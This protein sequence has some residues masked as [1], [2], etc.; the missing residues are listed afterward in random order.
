MINSKQV[1]CSLDANLPV[2]E[3][4]PS[5]SKFDLNLV[6]IRTLRP[7]RFLASLAF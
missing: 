4:K 7:L 6:G 1:P 2:V 5:S 3:S